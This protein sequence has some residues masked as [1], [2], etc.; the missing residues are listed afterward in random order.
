MRPPWA[1]HSARG[2]L[3]LPWQQGVLDAL[4]APPNSLAI[5]INT[6]ERPVGWL[7]QVKEVSWP[8]SPVDSSILPY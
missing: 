2:R 5:K 8:A 3:P 7:S 1:V 4:L 6:A